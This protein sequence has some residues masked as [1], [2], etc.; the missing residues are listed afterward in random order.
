MLTL[1]SYPGL[2]GVSDNNPFGLKV[3]AFLKLCGLPFRHKHILDAS[4]A[5]RAQ[6]PYLTDGDEIIGDSDAIISYL[7]RRDN[8]SIDKELTSS[9]SDMDLLIRRML[10]DLYWV[11][12]YSRWKDDRFYPLFRDAILQTHPSITAEALRKAREH[13]FQRYHFQGIGR[14]K[15]DA[16]YA[17]GTASLR[18]LANLVPES[19][20]VFGVHPCGIDASIYG[21]IANIY[22]YEIATPLKAFVVS[23]PHLVR[24]CLSVHAS[25]QR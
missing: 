15:P 20:F 9:Q 5:P 21:F 10:D 11:M 13:N 23:Q 22:F 3:Y 14:Y 25:V 1:Y 7:T 6:L 12:S 2:F 8:L 16:V 19:G 18:V 4:E 17:R 24:H